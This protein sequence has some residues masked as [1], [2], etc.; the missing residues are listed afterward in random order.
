VSSKFTYFVNFVYFVQA[1][2]ITKTDQQATTAHV[3][4]CVINKQHALTEHGPS[5]EPWG[6]CT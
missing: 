4:V 6:A 5:S 2:Q 3:T 1:N